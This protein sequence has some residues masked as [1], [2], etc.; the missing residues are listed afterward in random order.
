VD[1]I[2]SVVLVVEMSVFKKVVVCDSFFDLF[3]VVNSS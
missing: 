3:K 1:V 2:G